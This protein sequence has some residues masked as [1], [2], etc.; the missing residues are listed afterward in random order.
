VTEKD[1]R[2]GYRPFAVEVARLTPLSPHFMRVTLA[3]EGLADLG[4]DGLD[5]RIKLVFPH[6]DGTFGDAGWED[7][8]TIAAGDWYRRWRALPDHERNPFRTYTVRLPRPAEREVDVDFVVHGDGGPAARWLEAARPGDRVI[9][10]GPDARSRHSATGIEWRPGAAR[11][12]LLAGDETALP[13]VAAILAALPAGARAHVVLEV[14]DAGDRLPL[15][16]AAELTVD[17]IVRGTGE[18]RLVAAVEAWTAAHPDRLAGAVTEAPQELP[19]VD[20]DA[21]I[22][23][24]APA[25]AAAGF[26]A[27]LA[28][29]AGAITALRRHLVRGLGVDRSR[30]AFM[31]Y[32]RRGRAEAQ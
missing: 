14:P 10:V 3:G 16:C 31:G 25:A 4:T 22:L 8:A 30:V 23:W 19:A 7:E 15:D 24:E 9:L 5:Q 29:E 2:P 21:E 17:C 32:W 13:A 1:G 20:I 28:G 11:E 27:W 18:S 12:L 26:Y 6:P